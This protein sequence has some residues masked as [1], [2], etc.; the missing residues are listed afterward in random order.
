MFQEQ[1]VVRLSRNTIHTYIYMGSAI[2]MNTD[3]RRFTHTCK[4][5]TASSCS[6]LADQDES[7]FI[8]KMYNVDPSSTQ[9]AQTLSLP[10][11]WHL[12]VP[13]TKVTALFF[14]L[15]LRATY[16]Q[17]IPFTLDSLPSRC[18]WG[19]QSPPNTHM[20]MGLS[21]SWSTPMTSSIADSQTLRSLQELSW[22]PWFLQ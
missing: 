10:S 2:Q 21:G 17:W 7:P 19:L 15:V 12:G 9:W 18:P 16:K 13:A 22:T 1:P 14:L 11:C 8:K 6:C 4:Q 3:R 20:E 5:P